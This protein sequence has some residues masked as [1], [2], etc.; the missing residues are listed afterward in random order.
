MSPRKGVKGTKISWVLANGS[1]IVMQGDTQKNWYH[2]IPKEK[3]ITTGRI[4]LT[5]R[6]LE[7]T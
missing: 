6:Q 1:L 7:K 3:A 4:S 5:F 2:E